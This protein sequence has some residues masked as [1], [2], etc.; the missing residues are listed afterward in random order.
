MKTVAQLS[1]RS[2]LAGGAAAV[3]VMA[4]RPAWAEGPALPDRWEVLRR[5]AA[6]GLVRPGEGGFAKAALPN[7]LRFRDVR[8]QGVAYC[9]TPQ[10]VAD[11]LSW[12]RDYDVP[13][14]IRGGGHSYAGYS[15]GH[16]LVI[17]MREMRA[18]HFVTKLVD[19]GF[20]D[21][22]RLKRMLIHTVDAE[23]VLSRLG[24]SSK[25][26]A[27]WEFLTRLRDLGRERAEIF[28]NAHFD[29]IGQESSTTFEEKFL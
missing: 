13:F 11:V 10:M 22:G 5:V 1:R 24:A 16:D 14:V 15:S 27:D 29:K 4:S 18:I 28:L 26:N 23:D 2:F 21:G 8:P 25:L 19:S 7:N 17:D 12:C 6:D 20:T 9:R 3:G